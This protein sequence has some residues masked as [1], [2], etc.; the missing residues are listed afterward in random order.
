V[1][2]RCPDENVLGRLIDG[3]LSEPERSAIEH[4]AGGCASCAAL[5][6][7]CAQTRPPREV[8]A[9]YALIRQLGAGAMGEVWEA[10]DATL[11]RRVALKLLRPE[12]RA[13]R[14]FQAR[15]VREARALAQVRH[16]AVIA[17][18]DLEQTAGGE[19][20]LALE[21]VAGATAREWCA[22]ARRTTREI[23]ALWS[24]VA[25][26]LAAVHRA[27]IVHRDLKPDN[28]LIDGAGRIAIVDFGLASLGPSRAS[29]TLTASGQVVGTPVYM[30]LEQLRGH[31][32]TPRSDQFALCVCVWEAITGRRPFGG[33]TLAALIRAMERRP[34]VPRGRDR[35][36]L[37]VL[38]RGLDPDP[39]RR[40]RDLDELRSALDATR[41]GL[42]AR[43]A[44][45]LQS[46][47]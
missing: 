23:V 32:A 19:L 22:A 43:L 36:V 35:K 12:A 31:D 24:T 3:E 41:R 30:P 46:G 34:A 1:S 25:D 20:L 5:L 14:A 16:P 38:A 4:H 28:V 6:E 10:R 21:L 29:T 8:P 45:A 33:A 42:W 26:G 17:V 11:D 37:E 9:R 2:D 47:R 40:W 44:G 7:T 27:G 39:A 13:D 15:L 18:Y